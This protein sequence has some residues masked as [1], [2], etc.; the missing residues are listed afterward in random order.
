MSLIARENE[1]K[2]LLKRLRFISLLYRGYSVGN[3]SRI[4][5]VTP[6]CGYR[7]LKRWNSGGIIKLMEKKRGRKSRIPG[8]DKL[9]FPQSM[10]IP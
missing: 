4:L 1:V 10:E 9:I 3:A 7:W 5:G 2:R 8:I 6:P